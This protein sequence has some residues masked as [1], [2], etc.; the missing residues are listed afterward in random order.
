M[1]LKVS[2]ALL[3]HG[4]TSHTTFSDLLNGPSTH[5]IFGCVCHPSSSLGLLV[6]VHYGKHHSI[7]AVLPSLFPIIILTGFLEP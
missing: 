2:T 3:T 6:T 5:R 7:G 1:E 4:G